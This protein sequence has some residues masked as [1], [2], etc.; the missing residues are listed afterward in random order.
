MILLTSV[1]TDYARLCRY[2]LVR[3]FFVQ[4]KYWKDYDPFLQQKEA[5]FQKSS[6]AIY[7]K[8][9]MFDD[10]ALLNSRHVQSW[11]QRCTSWRE[12]RTAWPP[13]LTT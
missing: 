2:R 3:S 4:T 1:R 8:C 12:T 9:H 13:T 10:L 6:K 5:T 7:R 11:R